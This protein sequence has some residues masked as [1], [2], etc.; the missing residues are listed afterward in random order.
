R[1]DDPGGLRWRLAGCG[2]LGVARAPARSG[3]GLRPD[4]AQVAGFGIRSSGAGAARPAV[5]LADAGTAVCR[6]NPGALR[7]GA[8]AAGR[9]YP[10]RA[11]RAAGDAARG[12][13]LES[14]NPLR[15]IRPARL[16][17]R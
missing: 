15:E 16:T 9:G 14:L 5:A 7:T 11:R 2:A 10:A 4:R 3:D 17:P 13:Y 8:G 1:L 12:R 6:C